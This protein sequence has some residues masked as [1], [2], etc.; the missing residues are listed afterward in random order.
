M[1][2]DRPPDDAALA[3]A[4]GAANRVFNGPESFESYYK[5]ADEKLLAAAMLRLIP[6]LRLL[7]AARADCGRLRGALYDMLDLATFA[8]AAMT[9][10]EFRAELMKRLNAAL[11]TPP[12]RPAGAG[13]HITEYDGAYKCWTHDRV[14]GAVT[15]PD[16]PCA[17]WVEPTGAGA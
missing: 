12:D 2:T 7:R 4:E 6:E 16:A 17:G 11:P 3:E 9:P 10:T 5:R 8:P 14:W 15:H 13:C 1:P